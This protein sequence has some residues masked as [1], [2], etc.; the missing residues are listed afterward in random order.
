MAAYR[1]HPPPIP[2]HPTKGNKIIVYRYVAAV[3][4]RY[5]DTAD[6]HTQHTAGIYGRATCHMWLDN[7]SYFLAL[8]LLSGA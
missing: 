3:V 2:S 4:K 1:S 8:L 5:K 7:W 6:R